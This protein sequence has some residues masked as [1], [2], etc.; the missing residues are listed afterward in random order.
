LP[1]KRFLRPF[2]GALLALAAVLAHAHA[3]LQSAVPADG[4]RVTHLPA[5]LTLSFSEPARLTVLWIEQEGGGK[6]KVAELPAVTARQ[7][8]VPLPRL[9]PGSYHITFRTLSSD[10]HVAPGELRFTFAPEPPEAS[11]TK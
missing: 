10:G 2:L 3:H 4:S 8:S 11:A 5:A 1:V 7:V 6:Q 9:A